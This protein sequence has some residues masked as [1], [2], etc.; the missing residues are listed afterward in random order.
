M[1]EASFVQDIL[2]DPQATVSGRNRRSIGS[3]EGSATWEGQDGAAIG[4]IDLKQ[5]GELKREDDA[6]THAAIWN[7]Q[8]DSAER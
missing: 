1:P 7:L 4:A 8:R 3:G 2:P 5:L 6:P